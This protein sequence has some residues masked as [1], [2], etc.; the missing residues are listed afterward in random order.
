MRFIIKYFMLYKV[1][2]IV[3]DF[4][5]I[6]EIRVVLIDVD[7][8]IGDIVCIFIIDRRVFLIIVI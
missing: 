3:V 2:F 5:I 8:F 1:I 4:V 7:V 6:T